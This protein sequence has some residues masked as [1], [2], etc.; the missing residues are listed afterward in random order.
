[1]ACHLTGGTQRR[2]LWSII[3]VVIRDRYLSCRMT[4]IAVCTAYFSAKNMY[5]RPAHDDG[6]ESA[7]KK[8][9]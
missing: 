6:L 4:K 7:L 3:H 1:M 9:L 8:Y 2:S 5:S